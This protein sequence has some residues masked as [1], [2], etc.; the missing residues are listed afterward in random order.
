MSVLKVNLNQEQ[1]DQIENERSK[2]NAGEKID[3]MQK[4][5]VVLKAK[6]TFVNDVSEEVRELPLTDGS[7]I[8]YVKEVI[9]RLQADENNLVGFQDTLVFV[10]RSQDSTEESSEDKFYY[11][12]QPATTK[13]FIGTG[14]KGDGDITGFACQTAIYIFDKLRDEDYLDLKL[15]Y[16]FSSV[17]L[18]FNKKRDNIS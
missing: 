16:A 12:N 9:P 11:R 4:A 13:R 5:L 8:Q 1:I 7:I 10:L 18:S 3:F 2:M 6:S 17:L 15:S 14:I